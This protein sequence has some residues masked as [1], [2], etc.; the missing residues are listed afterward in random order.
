MAEAAVE[1]SKFHLGCEKD[2]SHPTVEYENTS[3]HSHDFQTFENMFIGVTTTV[4]FTTNVLLIVAL[5]SSK[6]LR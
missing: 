5:A 2:F 4:I 6:F 3:H 1:V